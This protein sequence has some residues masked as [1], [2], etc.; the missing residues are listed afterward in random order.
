MWVSTISAWC[1]LVFD[2]SELSPTFP[3]QAVSPKAR[4]LGKMSTGSESGRI[5]SVYT[6]AINTP[7][8][9]RQCWFYQATLWD[10]AIPGCIYTGWREKSQI[11]YCRHPQPP[12]WKRTSQCLLMWDPDVKGSGIWGLVIG[13]VACSHRNARPELPSFVYAGLQ[14]LPPLDSGF[15]KRRQQIQAQ[16]HPDGLSLKLLSP[17]PS[18]CVWLW[19]IMGLNASPAISSFQ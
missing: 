9:S 2:V 13:A 8:G 14:Q 7:I 1:R 12:L 5:T 3:L 6:W 18:I 16:N 17:Q 10:A 11:S 19:F 4:G 15:C